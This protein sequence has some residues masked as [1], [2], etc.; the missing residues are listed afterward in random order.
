MIS[1]IFLRWTWCLLQQ[2]ADQWHIWTPLL[3]TAF[4]SLLWLAEDTQTASPIYDPLGERHF[5][6][7]GNEG[8][9]LQQEF[10]REEFLQ[11]PNQRILP[12][13]LAIILPTRWTYWKLTSLLNFVVFSWDPIYTVLGLPDGSHF[14]PYS[15]I[16]K[17]NKERVKCV[18]SGIVATVCTSVAFYLCDFDPYTFIKY[19]WVG[20][21]VKLKLTWPVFPDSGSFSRLLDRCCHLHAT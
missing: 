10:L 4:L 2:H 1:L 8:E 12:V 15:R 6:S 21:Q 14:W 16:F 11:A 17:N 9:I 18:I 20:D 3:W 5:P 19:Y 7:M 13:I